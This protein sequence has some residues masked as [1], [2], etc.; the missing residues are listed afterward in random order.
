MIVRSKVSQIRKNNNISQ[1]L[2]GTISKD[3]PDCDRELKMLVGIVVGDVL[4]NLKKHDRGAVHVHWKKTRNG[5]VITF[6]VES[7]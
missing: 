2:I 7:F 5:F 4:S 1:A 3:I 6:Q